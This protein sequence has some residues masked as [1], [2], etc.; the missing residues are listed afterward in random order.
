MSAVIGEMPHSERAARAEW[1]NP[2][3][4]IL[5]AHIYV[6]D[7]QAS[8][9]TLLE[10]ILRRAGFTEISAYA[11]GAAALAAIEAQEPDILLLDLR[12]P[13]LDGF[14]VLD[15]ID[16]LIPPDSFLPVI[17]LTAD[18]ER[19][20]RTRALAAGA[21]NF[22]TKPIDADEVVLRTVNL[23]RA[24]QLHQ[25][26]R[27]RNAGL[28][29]EV[30]TAVTALTATE[31]Q[32]RAVA[33]SLTRLTTAETAE[34]TAALVCAEMATLPDLA[35]VGLFAFTGDEVTMPLALELEITGGLG[36]DV[37]LP[38]E[39]SALL[40]RRAASGAWITSDVSGQAS[41]A[42][43]RWLSLT[44]LTAAAFAPLHSQTGPVGLL[45]AGV[46]SED[47]AT[48]LK[49]MLPALEA[50]ASLA[51]A[52]LAPM[53]EARQRTEEVRTKVRRTIAERAFEPVFQPILDL[54]TETVVGYEALTRFSDGTRPDRVFAAARSEG[55]GVELEI[56]SLTA[57]LAAASALPKG[58]WLSLNVSP[59][60]LLA[61]GALQ[62]LLARQT[63]HVVLE[64]TE[65]TE[66]ADYAAIRV[67]VSALGPRVTVAVDDAGA[68]FASLHHIVEL[69][70]R[71]LKVDVSLV[72]GVDRD[73]TR[74]AM[75]AGLAH[76]AARSGCEVIAEGIEESPELEM[77]QGLG[78]KFGQ[79]HLL[80][81]PEQVGRAAGRRGVRRSA[82]G[83]SGRPP[84]G[85][86]PTSSRTG[87]T[88][89]DPRGSDARKPSDHRRSQDLIAAARSTFHRR[90]LH[91]TRAFITRER[92]VFAWPRSVALAR[93]L[94][95]VGLFA[96]VVQ[97]LT[98]PFLGTP[99]SA[100]PHAVVIAAT[101]LGSVALLVGPIRA[102]T[103]VSSNVSLA[104]AIGMQTGTAAVTGTI[105]S[106]YLSGYVVLVLAA[107]LFAT[108]PILLM[109][110]LGSIAGLLV[111]AAV[112]LEFNGSD[113]A[114]MS[115]LG[116]VLTLV[117]STS[118]LLVTRLRHRMRRVEQRLH[119]SRRHASRQWV[120]ARTDSLTGL[121]NRRAFDDD[122]VA[123]LVDRRIDML[124]LAMVDVDGLKT[125]NDTLGHPMGDRLIQAMATDLRAH[126]RADDR[127]YRIGGD[128]FAVLSTSRDPDTLEARLGRYVEVDVA[129][130]G[131]R[132]A[133]VGI[134]RRRPG[135]GPT[136]LKSR[137][138]ANLYESKRGRRDLGRHVPTPS[139]DL[140]SRAG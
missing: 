129:G 2:A 91:V 38:R 136:E 100:E 24:R 112:D 11:D 27:A 102:L 130:L 88:Q 81:R 97:V 94:G 48:H 138:D 64:I 16:D 14:G 67:A 122:L 39:L 114:T 10:R 80:G 121:G 74:Q 125:V 52:L 30:R 3:D 139:G 23:L 120:N 111:L 93:M 55:L 105:E 41:P 72:H 76:F 37:P 75:I 33:E 108:A 103:P 78:I 98:W 127:V 131:L 5:G 59:D 66:I 63:R 21:T 92:Q 104:A 135:D 83:A 84:R 58:A 19:E 20:A 134:A 13:G 61:E 25:R 116:T 8:N 31:A 132:R 110:V 12:M 133:S 106:P 18:G 113:A 68:G 28:V 137:A 99:A 118:S 86:Q 45:A 69:G 126:V 47:G 85:D 62:S 50:F 115:T 124:I 17:V 117:G 96:A 40:Q 95:L 128:E 140:I 56:A 82:F 101:A 51:S 34:A 49:T 71:F 70:P 6:V 35:G 79:G 1:I 87:S 53:I 109:T 54:Q 15:A 32:W 4:A 57:A 44:G 107:G 119:S 7:D 43:R 60:L 42:A 29:D 22:I 26:L 73:P 36:V 9:L 65:H 46:A 123:A 89:V 77:L 90:V